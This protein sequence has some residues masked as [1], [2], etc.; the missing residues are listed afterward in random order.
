[1]GSKHPL[2]SQERIQ[3]E[4]LN[5]EALARSLR[6]SLGESVQWDRLSRAG[7]EKALHGVATAFH[8]LDSVRKDVEVMRAA[9]AHI[10]D[11]IERDEARS[12]IV[13]R[14]EVRARE[15]QARYFEVAGKG[16]VTV[17]MGRRLDPEGKHGPYPRTVHLPIDAEGER[18]CEEACK[19]MRNFIRGADLL[20]LSRE[21]EKLNLARILLQHSEFASPQ[22]CS[23]EMVAR[24]TDDS[25]CPSWKQVAEIVGHRTGAHALEMAV[26]R[27]KPGDPYFP[28]KDPANRVR[29]G[30]GTL[31]TLGTVALVRMRLDAGVEA[32]ARALEERKREA[33]R[34]RSAASPLDE[35][36]LSRESLRRLVEIGPERK[37]GKD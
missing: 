16:E 22:K 36:V 21:Q 37:R 24:L 5:P 1:M 30:R 26:R 8:R 7:F 35:R 31:P 29:K 6:A 34:V 27:S 14:V 20:T 3:P 15:A 13:D 28:L 9:T 19:A 10:A 32:E 17:E 25:P 23:P 11:G 12:R 18:L 33:Q 4:L 2:G